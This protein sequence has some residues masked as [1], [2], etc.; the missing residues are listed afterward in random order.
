MRK[1]FCLKLAKRSSLFILIVVSTLISVSCKK[2]GMDED[3]LVRIYV[4]NIILEETHQSN[5]EILKQEKEKL[6]KKFNTTK[7]GFET[8]LINMG[9][10]REKWEKFFNKSRT[11]LEEL[12]KSGA[13]N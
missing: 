1:G 6:F 9:S 12:R 5:P 11:L 7:E 2:E 8:E 3:K 4:E 10:D 13:V